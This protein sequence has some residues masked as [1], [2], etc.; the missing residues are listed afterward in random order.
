MRRMCIGEVGDVLEHVLFMPMDLM[1]R[2]IITFSLVVGGSTFPAI[3]LDVI[4][5]GVDHQYL[6][7]LFPVV[8]DFQEDDDL[9]LYSNPKTHKRRL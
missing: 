3:I 9:L 6:F 7:F 4:R 1:R 2:L 5:C 8:C